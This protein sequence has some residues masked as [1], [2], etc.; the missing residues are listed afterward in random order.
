LSAVD[1]HISAGEEKS[2]AKAKAHGIIMIFSWMFFGT[3]AIFV[4]RYFKFLF[5]KK[6][7][8]GRSIWY[9]THL[10][11]MIFVMVLSI[12]AFLL[13]LSYT[14][15]KWIG[16]REPVNFAHSIFG[17]IVIV[18]TVFIVNNF[19]KINRKKAD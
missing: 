13:I 7:L 1:K 4:A 6:K 18:L 14:N 9:I 19:N 3:T 2:L 11:F 15:W 12:I 16:I 8:L 17:I 10:S 5:P